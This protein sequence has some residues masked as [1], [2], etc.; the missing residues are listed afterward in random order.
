MKC[1]ELTPQELGVA[2]GVLYFFDN[3][4]TTYSQLEEYF[5]LSHNTIRDSL[6]NLEKLNII[7]RKPVMGIEKG[8]EII[9][10]PVNSWY[11]SGDVPTSIISYSYKKEIEIILDDLNKLARRTDD[12]KF[13]STLHVSSLIRERFNEGSTLEDFKK[14][15]RNMVDWIFDDK[16]FEYYRPETLYRRSNF[17]KYLVRITKARND[18]RTTSKYDSPEAKQRAKERREK[19]NKRWGL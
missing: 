19:L 14:V 3:S 16:M 11:T 18:L 12:K 1:G 5:H 15:H 6:K 8:L 4:K 13:R 2:V 17:G 10:R 9:C 7:L